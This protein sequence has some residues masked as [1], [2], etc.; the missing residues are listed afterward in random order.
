MILYNGRYIIIIYNYRP[1]CTR[2][3]FFKTKTQLCIYYSIGIEYERYVERL[4]LT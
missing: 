3:G 1:I 2:N 4:I